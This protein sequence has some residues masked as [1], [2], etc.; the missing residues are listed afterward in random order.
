VVE[1]PDDGVKEVKLK[2]AYGHEFT[3]HLDALGVIN[4]QMKVADV[5]KANAEAERDRTDTKTL[6]QQQKDMDT[7]K[8]AR[9]ELDKVGGDVS[10]L[11]PGSRDALQTE[12]VK[13]YSIDSAVYDRAQTEM[14]KRLDS[15]EI[16]LD[17]DGNPDVNSEAY[18]DANDFLAESREQLHSSLT[19]MRQL[20]HGYQPYN[21]EPKTTPAAAPAGAPAKTLPD[22]ITTARGRLP[23]SLPKPPAAGSAITR[24]AFA[25]YLQKFDGD[26]EKAKQ[27]AIGDGWG[28]PQAQ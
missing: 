7:V 27:A 24:A 19:L 10:K 5:N 20:G 12:A 4:Y 9:K 22:E 13:Q 16:P 21:P 14:K 11:S 18:K 3:T 23:Q 17:K 28:P 6:R 8:G 26:V 25:P 1:I 2:D 15:G